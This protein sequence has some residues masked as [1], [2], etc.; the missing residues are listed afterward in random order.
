MNKHTK[1]MI[2]KA[3][4]HRSTKEEE[5]GNNENKVLGCFKSFVVLMSCVFV[6][7]YLNKYLFYCVVVN[8]DR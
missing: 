4:I 2:K 6:A 3:H 1:N 8:T 7:P 5:I